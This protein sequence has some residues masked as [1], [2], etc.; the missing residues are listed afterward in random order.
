MADGAD[1]LQGTD[2]IR[3]PAESSAVQVPV[4]AQGV[5]AGGEVRPLKADDRGRMRPEVALAVLGL[6]VRV[7]GR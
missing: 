3:R 1:V 7:R 6:W 4:I 2:R 5:H